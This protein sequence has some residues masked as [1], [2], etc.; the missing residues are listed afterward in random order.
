MR[1]IDRKGQRVS[2]R[3]LTSVK[4]DSTEARVP[5]TTFIPT[6]SLAIPTAS[7]V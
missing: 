6:N 4:R 3:T 1:N 2:D 5:L 7:T